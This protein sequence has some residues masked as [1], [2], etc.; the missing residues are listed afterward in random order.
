MFQKILKARGEHLYYGSPATVGRAVEDYVSAVAVDG[1]G[2]DDALRHASSVLDE[3]ELVP[4]D[5]DADQERLELHKGEVLEAISKNALEGIQ[6]A[7]RQ[8]NQI[9]GQRKLTASYSGLALDFLGFADFLGGH[10]VAELKVKTS[11]PTETKKG[12][13]KRVGSLPS[14]PD[15]KHAQQAAFYAD[16]LDMPAS[17][18]YA[19]EKEFRIFDETNCD[20][21]TPEGIQK[22]V[23]ELRSRAWSRENLMRCAPNQI[24]LMQMLAPDWTDWGWKVDPKFLQEAREIWGLKA[25]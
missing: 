25:A 14:K 23:M 16:V 17:L 21:L 2:E 6:K 3:H 13:G 5:K 19:N 12:A 15:A 20:E 10:R 7:L 8:A 18:V 9:L 11:A 24:T 22:G 4:W 1:M